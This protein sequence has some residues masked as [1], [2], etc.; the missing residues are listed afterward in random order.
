MDDTTEQQA[1]GRDSTEEDPSSEAESRPVAVVS[2]VKT[3]K[4]AAE[5]QDE[6]DKEDE[7][8]VGTEPPPRP[9]WPAWVELP[10]LLLVG[11]LVVT[12]VNVF[13]AQPYLIPSGSMEN[14]LHVGDRVVVNKLAY[15]FGDIKRGDVVVF[16]GSGT[17]V[18][19]H[20]EPSLF[21]RAGSLFG[22]TSPPDDKFVKRV[23]GV[24][25]DRVTCCDAQGRIMVN[26]VPQNETYLYPG[27]SPSTVAFDVVV[28]KGRIW[29]Q[30]DHR[31]NS[32]DSRGHLGSPGGGFI[33]EENVVGRV[34]WVVWPFGRLGGVSGG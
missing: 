11:V 12:V 19:G 33:E 30:G 5:E 26:G 29:V 32:L 22:L 13:V 28:P 20:G 6:E 34:E 2:L 3:P 15:R 8:D 23:I 18:T 16:D 25:G 27:D 24:G 7:E 4:P 21:E 9:R 14:T 1:T 17:F 10:V 31:S